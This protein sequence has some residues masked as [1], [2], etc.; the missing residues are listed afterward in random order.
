VP[1]M[2]DLPTGATSGPYGWIVSGVVVLLVAFRETLA[3]IRKSRSEDNTTALTHA[4][5]IIRGHERYEAR[6]EK[7]VQDLETRL[8]ERDNWWRSQVDALWEANAQTEKKER[9]CQL[10]IE[11]LCS[12]LRENDIDIP[13]WPF[14]DDL[15]GT[16]P[17][18]EGGPPCP[19]G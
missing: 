17:P 16:G 14:G 6:L 5:T 7:Q 1:D 11:W 10:R 3:L 12:H 15:N 13:D 4:N 18:P 8:N 2:P 19:T 9:R